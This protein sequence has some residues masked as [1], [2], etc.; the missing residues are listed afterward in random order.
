MKRISAL[1]L[2]A[3]LALTTARAGDVKVEVRLAK[4]EDSRPATTFVA[5]MPV[6]YA[7]FNTTGTKKGNSLRGVWIAEDVGEA[8]PKETK[9]DESSLV[10][11]KDNFVGSFSISKPT[12][13]WSL[14]K[15]RVEIYSGSE[16]ATKVKFKIIAGKSENDEDQGQDQGKDKD[17]E[18]DDKD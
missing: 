14:G 9:I 13:G 16:L 17:K 8:A 15:Y 7:F 6:L 11:D 2:I 1:L 12:K 18:D 10:A 3:A 4:D 5:D